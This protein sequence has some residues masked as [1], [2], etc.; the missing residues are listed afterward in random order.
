MSPGLVGG[1]STSEPPEKPWP[2][3][4]FLKI[5][6]SFCV[7][8]PLFLQPVLLGNMF[9]EKK[10]L[11]QIHLSLLFSLGHS[12][13]FF[14]FH[15]FLWYWPFKIF[16][17]TFNLCPCSHSFILSRYPDCLLHIENRSHQFNFSH[18]VSSPTLLPLSPSFQVLLLFQRKRCCPHALNGEGPSHG[19]SWPYKVLPAL[20]F[21]PRMS[22]IHVRSVCLPPP[23]LCSP[24]SVLMQPGTCWLGPGKF[25]SSCFLRCTLPEWGVHKLPHPRQLRAEEL[26]EL[27]AHNQLPWESLQQHVCLLT[28]AFP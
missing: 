16:T 11:G 21:Y 15:I 19:Y 2:S 20:D 3:A 24:W 22:Q 8:W 5:M 27:L 4:D 12:V 9:L 7:I 18:M 23:S 6:L 14:F 17:Y 26:V 10:Y 13:L 25:Q 1:F 28:F